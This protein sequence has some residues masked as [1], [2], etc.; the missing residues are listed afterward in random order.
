MR[1]VAKQNFLFDKASLLEQNSRINFN[2]GSENA[3]K[4]ILVAIVI[5]LSSVA[6]VAQAPAAEESRPGIAGYHNCRAYFGVMWLDGV[7]PGGTQQATH[8][9][10]SA[11]QSEWWRAEGYKKHQGLCYVP[12]VQE[13]EGRVDVQCAGCAADWVGRFRWVVFEHVDAKNK[14]AHESG[15]IVTGPA[16]SGGLANSNRPVTAVSASDPNSRVEYEVEVVAT[17]A[18]VYAAN[19]PIRPPSGQDAQLFYHSEEKD[20]SRKDPEAQVA[21]NDRVALQA[22][23]EFILKNVK[24]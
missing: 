16:I 21:R 1:G 5:L 7:L 12:Q 19:N 2:G 8:F 10:F 22:A 6:L 3:M 11:Q 4:C 17:G 15:A 18:A 13:R 14:R 24:R 9:G 23:A 20:K